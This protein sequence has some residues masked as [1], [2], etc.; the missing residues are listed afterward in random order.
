MEILLS[1]E[2]MLEMSLFI[3]FEVADIV[4]KTIEAFKQGKA[5]LEI[6]NRTKENAIEVENSK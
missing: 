6:N 1:D 5:A 2:F 4:N 3:V